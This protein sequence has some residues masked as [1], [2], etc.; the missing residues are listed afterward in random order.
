MVILK[1][2]SIPMPGFKTTA[3]ICSVSRWTENDVLKWGLL[4]DLKWPNEK[5]YLVTT[6][7]VYYISASYR[8]SILCILIRFG[9]MCKCF[10]F[11]RQY[12][13]IYWNKKKQTK[14][15]THTEK[16]SYTDIHTTKWW[17]HTKRETT[18]HKEI[19]KSITFVYT[20]LHITSLPPF[21]GIIY[22][23]NTF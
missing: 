19:H 18:K 4:S 20:A 14:H 7:K 16:C 13:S 12:Q 3:D 23:I 22:F 6:L 9:I 5:K 2:I 10:F 11:L 8:T 17:T 21:H 15:Y 1:W